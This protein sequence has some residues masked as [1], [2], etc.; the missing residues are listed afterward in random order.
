M[1]IHI[2]RREFIVMVGGAVAW[3]LAYS[4]GVCSV[5]GRMGRRIL[6]RKPVCFDRSGAIEAA[7]PSRKSPHNGRNADQSPAMRDWPLATSIVLVGR[8]GSQQSRP[9]GSDCSRTGLKL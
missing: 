1:A 9:D 6:G 7:K 5:N 8:E 2:R 4:S 3:P